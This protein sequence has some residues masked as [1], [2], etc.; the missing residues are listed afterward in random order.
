MAALNSLL[1]LAREAGMPGLASGFLEHY[2][3]RM[4]RSA[5]RTHEP[6]CSQ[7]VRSKMGKPCMW[8]LLRNAR[9]W[10]WCCA[11]LCRRSASTGG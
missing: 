10:R 8:G 7:P 6:V 11:G 2:G 3:R 1:R 5:R 4:R 9:S